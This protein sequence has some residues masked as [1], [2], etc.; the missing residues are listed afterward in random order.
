MTIKDMNEAAKIIRSEGAYGFE[1]AKRY[2]GHEVALG[3]LVLHLR[4]AL[5]V[6]HGWPDADDTE[7]RVMSVLR[8]RR[9]EV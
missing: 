7:E 9:I 8:R 2:V 5:N 1:R 6:R 4:G 3:M